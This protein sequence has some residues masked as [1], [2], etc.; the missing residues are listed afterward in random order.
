MAISTD[1]ACKPVNTMEIGGHGF[2]HRPLGKLYH[3]DQFE[4]LR[5]CAE[6]LRGFVGNRALLLSYPSGDFTPITVRIAGHLGFS[7]AFTIRR[8]SVERSPDPLEIGRFDCNRLP[9]PGEFQ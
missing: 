3:R 9:E 1:K 5:A 6:T 7:H 8:A 2:T 4:E